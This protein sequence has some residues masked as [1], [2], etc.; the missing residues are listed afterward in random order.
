MPV[1]EARAV[2]W[3]LVSP[4]PRHPAVFALGAVTHRLGQGMRG[5]HCPPVLLAHRSGVALIPVLTRHRSQPDV[6]LRVGEHK[7]VPCAPGCG[8]LEEQPSYSPCG[9]RENLAGPHRDCKLGLANPRYPL[10]TPAWGFPKSP[11]FLR[12]KHLPTLGLPSPIGSSGCWCLPASSKGLSRGSLW[13]EH[14]P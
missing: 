14:T 11:L 3:A 13:P 7:L 4:L 6:L 2:V 12:L 5:A 9:E 10:E 1:I 8:E